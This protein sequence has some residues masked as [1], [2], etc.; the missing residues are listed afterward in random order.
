[1]GRRRWG[2]SS[3]AVC[4]GGFLAGGVIIG[5]GVGGGL[6][7]SLHL[8]GRALRGYS[9]AAAQAGAASGGTGVRGATCRRRATDGEPASTMRAAKT[10]EGLSELLE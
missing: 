3:G 10:M 6:R 4:W 7:G 2:V 8:R 9:R 1:V 5:E